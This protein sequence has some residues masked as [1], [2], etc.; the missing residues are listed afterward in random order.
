MLVSLLLAIAV[1]LIFAGVA[2]VII[3]LVRYFFPAVES[4]FPDGFKKPLSLQY[5]SYYLLTGLLV[6]LIFGG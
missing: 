5:G 6:L 4:F 1:L 3:G 2:V